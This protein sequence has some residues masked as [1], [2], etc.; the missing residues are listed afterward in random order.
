VGETVVDNWGAGRDDLQVATRDGGAPST[1]TSATLTLH[2]LLFARN[3]K[4][5]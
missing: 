3:L 2:I 5:I 4:K 1:K